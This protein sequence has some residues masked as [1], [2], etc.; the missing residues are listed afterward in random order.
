[1]CIH[2]FFSHFN[3]YD[4]SSW[5]WFIFKYAVH[6]NCGPRTIFTV[7]YVVHRN[8]QLKG[9]LCCH[10]TTDKEDP[11]CSTFYFTKFRIMTN[12]VNPRNTDFFMAV[13]HVM[14]AKSQAEISVR[15]WELRSKVQTPQSSVV[16]C[17]FMYWHQC[18][19]SLVLFIYLPP[20]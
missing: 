14:I 4:T 1:M 8:S 5:A 6:T 17:C 9:M 19:V 11:I 7:F 20:L 18:D 13:I 12:C 10:L 15:W 16:L 3:A 2:H